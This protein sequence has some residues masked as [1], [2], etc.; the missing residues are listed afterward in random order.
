N[1]NTWMMGEWVGLGPSAASQHKGWRGS[2]VADIT[3]WAGLVARGE[4]VTLDRTALTASL[5]AEDALVF[6][7]RM[8]SGVDVLRLRAR[9]PGAPWGRV[10]ALIDRLGAEGLASREEGR[11]RLER[12]GRL[13]ADSIGSEIMVAFDAAPAVPAGTA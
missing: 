8:N 6:G 3:E 11:V 7:L 4:R 9:C 5:L 10:E 13:V 12:R 2:N 1:I